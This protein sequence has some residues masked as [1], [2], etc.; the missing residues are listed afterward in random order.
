[1][2]VIVGNFLFQSEINE[3]DFKTLIIGTGTP[4]DSK[5]Q[6]PKCSGIDK[7]LWQSILRLSTSERYLRE[8]F[9]W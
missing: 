8:L 5:A 3:E 7:Q 1:M 6:M 2:I 4:V 9:V